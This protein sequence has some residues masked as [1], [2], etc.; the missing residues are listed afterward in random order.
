MAKYRY[1]YEKVCNDKHNE[2]L[3]L[4]KKENDTFYFVNFT[5]FIIE[6][7]PK[8][9]FNKMVLKVKEPH[10]L[11]HKYRFNNISNINK[12]IYNY[13]KISIWNYT[14]NRYIYDFDINK[15]INIS[16]F[17][18][19][20][21]DKP[22]HIINMNITQYCPNWF[23]YL[24]FIS[25]YII[26]YTKLYFPEDDID[27]KFILKIKYELFTKTSIVNNLNLD[28]LENIKNNLLT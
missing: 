11:I 5:K 21:I 3:L 19:K 15:N 25:E 27:D 26:K 16:I 6:I 28:I 20:Y 8:N 1:L 4:L 12:N 17:I 10:I 9:D 13:D 18:I 24:V 22:S 23:A 7:I 14:F 2:N